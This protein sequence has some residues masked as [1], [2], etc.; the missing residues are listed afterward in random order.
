ML[1][2]SLWAVICSIVFA[3]ILGTSG[4]FAAE[5]TMSKEIEKALQEVE[6]TNS[7]IYEEIEKALRKSHELYDKYQED[8]SNETDA[9]KQT[10]IKNK[11]EE[12]I[13]D[14]ISKLDVKTQSM[15]RKGIEK[16][17]KSGLIVEIEWIEVN[18]ADRSAMIDPI[19]VM[20]W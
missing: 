10:H 5:N 11:Y 2:K 1:K 20:N 15:T 6:E 8:L 13:T 7:K 9:E 17:E 12:K 3:L 19:K 18:F 4:A 14:L 16:A